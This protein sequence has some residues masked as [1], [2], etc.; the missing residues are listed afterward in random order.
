MRQ[1][2]IILAGIVSVLSVVPYFIDVVRRK[3]KPRIVTWFVWSV[4]TAIATAAAFADHA[5]ASAVLTL[6]GSIATASIVVV[7]L[8]YGD[9]H[10]EKIDI[11]CLVGAVAGLVLWLV[12]GSPEI[13]I[14][15]TV[16][17]DFI[18]SVPTLWHSWKAPSEETAS[19]FFLS[20]FAAFL[21]LLAVE[22][23][24]VT[25]LTFPLYLFLMNSVIGLLITVRQKAHKKKS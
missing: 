24:S 21:S 22:R 5:Y 12:F 18:G 19:T 25:N 8:R 20:S 15:A 4:L 2:L 3:T 7:G 23:V 14:I 9:R 6:A 17:V 11:F 13:A 1:V 10:F 16:A